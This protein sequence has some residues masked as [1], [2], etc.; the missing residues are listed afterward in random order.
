[1]KEDIKPSIKDS[2]KDVQDD[3][4]KQTKDL[5]AAQKTQV[6]SDAITSLDKEKL[7]EA[8]I[9][10]KDGKIELFTDLEKN[11]CFCKPTK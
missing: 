4:A 5:K 10:V 9:K 11:G 6:G 2:Q 8:G 7:T 1:M 3:L